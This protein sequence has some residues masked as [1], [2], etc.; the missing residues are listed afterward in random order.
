MGWTAR[1]VIAIIVILLVG[2][3]AL[4]WYESNKP[5]PQRLYEQSVPVPQGG[6]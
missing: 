5:P 3:V 6:P 2:A 4:G 1:I